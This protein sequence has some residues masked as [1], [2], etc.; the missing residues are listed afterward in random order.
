MKAVPRIVIVLAAM[1][2][3]GS[4]SC[5]FNE[6]Q[7]PGGK[8]VDYSNWMSDNLA[9]L[10]NHEL[11]SV[12]IPGSHNTGMYTIQ[13]CTQILGFGANACNTQTQTQTQS[14]LQQLQSGVRYFDLRPVIY[15][16]T[17]YTGHYSKT[18]AVVLGCNG[19]LI[20]DILADVKTFMESSSDLVILKFSHYYD[21]DDEIFK[22]SETQMQ[23]L[24]CEV[25]NQLADYLYNQPAGNLAEVTINGYIS[26]GGKVLAVFD[27][28]P[29]TIP[30]QCKGI[31][32]Y[33]DFDEG[34]GDLIVYDNYADT[35]DLQKME[36]DQFKRLA[37]KSYHG[38]DNL[39]LLSWTLTQSAEQA[40]GCEFPGATSILDLAKEA[41]GAL[42]TQIEQKYYDGTI[43]SETTPNILYVDDV[44]TFVTDVA[45]W[46]NQKLLQ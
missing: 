34:S 4:V 26:A 5:S 8:V 20:S 7:D 1:S 21:R 27:D 25:S 19:A 28:L 42:Q 30:G 38:D 2:L 44:G 16:S 35:N 14:M 32:S 40:I 43:T 13:D 10:G 46:L 41:D 6:R 3:C 15:N 11:K 17:F 12:V 23:D 9:L 29:S 18:E 45:L 31:Y 37:N 33:A 22:F 36:G 24:A 39:F